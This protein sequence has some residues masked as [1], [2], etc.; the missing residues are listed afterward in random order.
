[1]RK[2]AVEQEYQAYRKEDQQTW[3]IMTE[4][5]MKFN[6]HL[7]SSEYKKGFQNLRL[8]EER[9]IKINELNIRLERLSGW[10]LV[11]VGGLIPT[12]DFFYMLIN[13][14]Y[15]VTTVIRKPH[16]ID[17]SEQPDIFHD[18]YGHV[19]MLTNEKFY[20]FLTEFSIIALKYINYE[21]AVEYLGRLY[22][23]TYEMGIIWEDGKLTPYGGAIITSHA[24]I[25]NV[26]NP[27]VPKHNFDLDRIFHTAYD[28]YKLQNEYFII[29]S[30]D[31]LFDC[32]ENLERTLIE[33]LLPSPVDATLTNYPVSRTLSSGFKNVIGF[34][35]DVQFRFPD[36]ISFVAGQPDEQFFDV[37]NNIRQIEDFVLKSAFESGNSRSEVF[38]KIGQYGRTKGII[39][40]IIANHLRID[41][42]INVEGKDI[43][44]TAGAQEAFAII[45][46]ALVNRDND[47]ILIEDPSYIGLSSFAKIFGYPIEAVQITEEG[48]HLQLLEEKLIE[49][50]SRGK[51]VKLIYVIPDYQNPTG[52]CMPVGNRLRLLDLAVRYDF[53]IIED[54]VYNSFTYTQK[55]NPTIKSL[56]RNKRVIYV[57][58][59]SKSLFPGLRIGY[60][61]ADQSFLSGEDLTSDLSDE[62]GKVKAQI[63]NNTSGISQAIVGGILLNSGY[64]LHKLNANKFNTYREKR[65]K[66]INCLREEIGVFDNDWAE[67]ISWN[68]PS[69]GFFIKMILPFPVSDN[70]V[71]EC[72]ENYGVVF[73]PMEYFY[74]H[75]GG[76]NEIRLT[77][78]NL[79]LAKIEEGVKKLA[80]FLKS[81][82][83]EK[84][85]VESMLG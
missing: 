66:I 15:P 49:C 12:K 67:D 13:K 84:V 35:N 11:P 53:L 59:F 74:L 7:A 56:D 34:L 40:N 17:F 62:L 43:L 63:T 80:A 77:F 44:I 57:G 46:A 70:E 25:E 9:I 6:Y 27:D 51:R 23:Y 52:A 26:N 2:L 71:I 73:C 54:G 36:T 39:N 47:M 28:P 82:V 75:E 55:K 72:A 22:W 65:N 33:S 48:I 42:S 1:M 58:S 78:S 20:R 5:H 45:V 10:T 50:Q 3:A 60:I 32:I 61:V 79:N 37:E 18:I 30:F 81:K 41:E 38:N 83:V 8:N 64:S 69:G 16:E 85:S 76:Q 19:P 68:E 4:R 24:E 31:D 29:G 21:K 14:K